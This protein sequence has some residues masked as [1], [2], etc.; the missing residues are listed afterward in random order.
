[1]GDL[2]GNLTNRRVL[3]GVTGSIAAYK[4]PDLVRR[5][6]D[7]GAEVQVLMTRGATAFITELTLQAVSGRRVRGEL[8]D[9]EAEAAMGHIELARWADLLVIAPASADFIARLAQGR[10]D[11]LLSAVC[12]ASRAP[13]AVAPAMN[14]EMWADAATRANVESLKRR[15]RILLGPGEGSQACGETGEGRMLE[16]LEIAAACERLFDS[17]ALSGLSVLITAGPT[18]EAIDPVRYISNRSSGKMGFALARAAVELGARVTLISG[19]VAL[20]SPERVARV[21]VESAEQMRRAVDANLNHT[22]IFIAAAAVADFRPRQASDHK[23][24]KLEQGLNLALEA[25][26]DILALAGTRQPRPFL[27]GFAAQTESVA[28]KAR[29]KLKNKR[30]DMI[31][32]NRVGLDE[33][34]RPFGFDSDENELEV[35]WEGGGESLGVGSKPRL[36]RDLLTLIANRYYDKQN[37]TE[38]SG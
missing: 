11:D 4:S 30:L 16:P 2:T 33:Q 35:F 36:A 6:R 22:D 34:G 18:R 19:P 10:A 37:A 38:N 17:R 1:M 5:L 9:P 27:V 21:D 13:L 25:T 20:P 24:G 23:I 8:L 7:A 3:L 12:L 31:A 29:E 32:A 15:G 28:D 14:R 26:P